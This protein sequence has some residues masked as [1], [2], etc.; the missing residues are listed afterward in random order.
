MEWNALTDK[1][2]DTYQVENVFKLKIASFTLWSREE[3]KFGYKIL[4][5]IYNFFS[6]G[7]S[8]TSLDLKIFNN[9][10][11]VN[12]NFFSKILDFIDHN[13]NNLNYDHLKY[14][15]LIYENLNNENLNNVYESL[16]TKDMNFLSYKNH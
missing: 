16:L 13:C 2:V 9:K 3:K 5:L 4:F 7:I 6:G 11:I 8:R 14:G 12:K 1:H 10:K 15:N